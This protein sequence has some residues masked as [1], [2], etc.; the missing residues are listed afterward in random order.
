MS[1][2]ILFLTLIQFVIFKNAI[3][4]QTGNIEQQIVITGQ[5]QEFSDFDDPLKIQFIYTPFCCKKQRLETGYFDNEGKFEFEIMNNIIQDYAV[6]YDEELF[7][8]LAQPGDSVHIEIKK[9]NQTGGKKQG[10][11]YEITSTNEITQNS[12]KILGGLKYYHPDMEYHESLRSIQ[13]VDSLFEIAKHRE[14]ILK[15]KIDS[16]FQ[17]EEYENEIMEEWLNQA[18]KYRYK[19]TVIVELLGR[20][21]GLRGEKRDSFY[22]LDINRY[23]AKRIDE[24]GK[25]VYNTDYRIFLHHLEMFNRITGSDAAIGELYKEKKYDEINEL[26]IARIKDNFNEYEAEM[27]ISQFYDQSLDRPLNSDYLRLSIEGFLREGKNEKFK[28]E[29]GE[30]YALL[31]DDEEW[32]DAVTKRMK[33]LPQ[34]V[35]NVIPEIIK[36]NSNK[37]IVIDFWATWCGPCIDEFKK[38]KEFISAFKEDEVVFV[39]LAYQSPENLWKKMISELEFEADHYL[40]DQNQALATKKIFKVTS[41]PHHVVIDKKGKVVKNK[42]PG[43]GKE[44][45]DIINSIE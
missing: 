4:S 15:K 10:Q 32:E 27:L 17:I 36:R 44:L 43:P 40:L 5:L 23:D 16:L 28:R 2:K 6:L 9:I 1:V 42:A 38:Y 34:G 45:K 30:K 31:F 33:A 7:I 13:D 3:Q 20:S 29:I 21:R 37:I 26:M 8:F 14:E 25:N 11:K 19:N 22:A 41:I 35:E 39:F 24:S 12:I 18:V